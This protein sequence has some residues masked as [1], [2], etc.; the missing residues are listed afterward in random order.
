MNRNYLETIKA[1]DGALYHLEYHQRRLN[2]TLQSENL[3]QLKKILDPPKSGLYRCRVIYNRASLRV[4]YLP[5]TKR[6]VKRLKLLFDDT[7]CYD[8][9]Y[10]E[11]GQLNHLYGQRGECDDTLIIQN[12]LVTD[13]TIANIAFFNGSVW[14]TPLMPL[15]RGTTRARLLD[16]KKIYE[17]EIKVEDISSYKRVALM[18]AMIDFDIIAENNIRD[19]IC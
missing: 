2:K 14:H 13:T 10:E 6:P 19:I 3:H 1:V 5:Y 15:L 4:E 9:K 16:A 11:R 8:K 17:K 12:G 18:N 7:L